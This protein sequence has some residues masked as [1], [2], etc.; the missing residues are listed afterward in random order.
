MRAADLF[1]HAIDSLKADRRQAALAGLGIVCGVA[2]VITALAIGEGARRAAMAEV[3]TL[4]ID[5]VIADSPAMQL[6]LADARGIQRSVPGRTP[7]APVR[8]ARVRAETSAATLTVTAAGV[9]PAWAQTTPVDVARGR[10]LS[11]ADAA[12]HRRVAVIGGVLAARLFPGREAVGESLRLASD[13]YLVVGTFAPASAPDT[14][15]VPLAALDTRIAPADGPDH[16]SRIVVA[17]ARSADAGAEA[18]RIERLLRRTHPADAVHVIVPRELV[19]ARL[20]ARRAFD[21]V[22]LSIGTLVL[23]ISGLGI[24]NVMLASVARRVPEIGV[25]RAVGAR[26][27]DIVGQFA[28][29]SLALCSAGGV[30]GLPLGAIATAIVGRLAGW[31]TAVSPLGMGIALGMAAIA[32]LAFGIYPAV[33]ASRWTPAEALR[34]VD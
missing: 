12:A 18:A 20:R 2:A 9:T 26:R 8:S 28:A 7:I 32:G 17:L 27:T 15:F 4:G 1:V 24:M 21:A 10:W 11:E 34:A 16:L 30:A 33:V 13:W 3:E 14:I 31:T 29:E 5:N 19:A 23:A 6:T 22:L 25:R